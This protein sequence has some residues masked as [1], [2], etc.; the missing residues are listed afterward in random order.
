M[1]FR[2]F[3]VETKETHHVFTFMRT[4]PPT[5]GHQLVVNKVKEVAAKVGGG[6]SVILS[7][8]QDASKN[9][10]TTA[11]KVKHAKR[12]FPKTNITTSNKEAPNFLDQAV[13]LHKQ[14]VTHLHVVAGS[15]RVQEY[16]KL[17][18]NYN[19]IYHS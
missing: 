19:G 14:G 15:D 3:L 4:N 17:L 9:P 16:T 8:T 6:H 1:R 18:N 10:L 12:F 13:K 7:H 5:T 11:Q 2:D